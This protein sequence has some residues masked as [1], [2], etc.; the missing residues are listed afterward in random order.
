M[1]K[2]VSPMK[3]FYSHVERDDENHIVSRKP[4][5]QHIRQVAESARGYIAALPDSLVR[6]NELEALASLIGVT[7]DFGKYTSF[8]QG[9]LLR[10]EN[11]GIAKNHSFVSAVLGA[12]LIFRQTYDEEKRKPH[13]ALLCFGAVLYHH[14]DLDNFCA[15]L[16]DIVAY[17]FPEKRQDLDLRPKQTLDAL[18]EKQLP[19]LLENAAA[20]ETELRTLYES[21]PALH[22]FQAALVTPESPFMMFLQN[23]HYS[24]EDLSD[25][26]QCAQLNFELYLLFSALIDADKRDAARLGTQSARGVIPKNIVRDYVTAAEFP[27]TDPVVRQIRTVLFHALDQQA[28]NM[29]LAQRIMT[30]TSPTGS[31]KTLAAL[32]FAVKL[33][34]R[35]SREQ[36]H[37]P[38][39][40]YA[41]P[42]TSIIDQ[43]HSV[44]EKVLANLPDFK[45]ND[46]LF[47][48]KHHH[49]MDVRYCSQSLFNEEL[50]V[51]KSLLMI[52]SWASE[53]IVTTYIQLFYS[54]IGA[55]NRHL[56]KYHNIA[57]SIILLDEVQNLPME[58]WPLVRR[59]LGWLAHEGQ[60]YIVLMTATQPLIFTPDE[61][62][63]LAP[64]PE[65]SFH[66]LDRVRF[67][68]HPQKQKLSDFAEAFAGKLDKEK[69][70]VVILNTIKS[71]VQFHK[72]LTEEYGV[73]SHEVF[74]LSTNIIPR[75]RRNRIET[76]RKKIKKGDP[77]LLISTQVIEAGVDLDFDVIY[78]DM[79][80]IDSLVQ[81]AGRANRNGLHGKGDVHIMRL[82]E[83]EEREYAPW[84]YGKL[85]LWVARSLLKDHSQLDEQ[86]FFELVQQ[87]Y[88]QLVA[89]KDLSAAENIYSSWWQ[90]SN[91]DALEDFRL[92]DERFDYVDVF[93]AIDEE[94][95]EIWDRYLLGVLYEKFFKKKQENYLKLRSQFR[96]FIVSIPRN[97]AKQFYWDYVGGDLRRPGYL[98]LEAVLD[99][100]DPITGYKR[101]ETDEVMI[102]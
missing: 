69:S 81:A 59:I 91:F 19:D 45:G 48:L 3:E 58:Y 85:H 77:L 37:T 79:A 2:R 98:S 21:F 64:N 38:H 97:A 26:G 66:V 52:E 20:I 53:I 27:P 62:F 24:Y 32:N 74:Y 72:M 75:E 82:M 70:Y 5:L 41:L 51:D 100:Y 56:K 11:H 13:D 92:I 68:I 89:K 60:C 78:R 28:E 14:G 16:R 87:N 39:I 102:F 12:Y 88:K 83:E 54:I 15:T 46:S 93:V 35:I 95:E 43:N 36:A 25:E 9:Y 96:Q 101:I 80:P 55:R 71:S 4:L 65:E 23:A 22:D 84:I 6:K 7:H 57:G 61:A 47:L 49:L 73:D 63:E 50:P 18:F 8:F 99:Y 29:P 1:D 42:F 86:R 90:S 34:D 17:T 10:K 44:F 30:L 31:G 76:I 94:A 67:F 40:I 33:R